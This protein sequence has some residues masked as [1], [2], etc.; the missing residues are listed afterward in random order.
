MRGPAQ[1]SATVAKEIR[2][3]IAASL[4]KVANG[5]VVE[6]QAGD[7][8]RQS[9]QQA[10]RTAE[11]TRAITEASHEQSAGIQQVSQA[12][13]Q[14]DQVAQ[15][16][17]VLVEEAGAAASALDSQAHNLVNLVGR[18]K[19]K[20]DL[21]RTPNV[22]PAKLSTNGRPPRTTLSSKQERE[23]DEWETF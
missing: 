5:N 13:M 1:R 10:H 20:H 23:Q 2:N 22:R 11:I 6:N 3:L 16:N 4:E 8:M 18:F 12:T 7:A 9:V 17:A 19:M 14:L 21:I 15:Q